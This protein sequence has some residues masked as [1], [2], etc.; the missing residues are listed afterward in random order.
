MVGQGWDLIDREVPC[1]LLWLRKFAFASPV[2]QETCQIVGV[3]GLLLNPM[4]TITRAT[5]GRFPWASNRSRRQV[6]F[7]RG[8]AELLVRQ[9]VDQLRAA[10]SRPIGC[11]SPSSGHEGQKSWRMPAWRLLDLTESNSRLSI[12]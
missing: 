2:N 3:L 12:W 4:A 9:L 5:V 1:N 10:A 8:G 6:P 11:R 7:V